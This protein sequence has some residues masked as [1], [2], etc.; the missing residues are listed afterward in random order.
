MDILKKLKISNIY[1]VF[2]LC[3]KQLMIA[4]IFIIYVFIL[5]RD[6]VGRKN[7]AFNKKKIKKKWKIW[8]KA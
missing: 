8:G 6:P 3:N 1:L 2:M 4:R 5:Y 7:R